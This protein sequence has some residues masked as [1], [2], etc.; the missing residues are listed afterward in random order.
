ML[1][2]LDA[3]SRWH[4]RVFGGQVLFLAL[5]GA[6]VL[7][8]DRHAPVLYL[9][10]LRAMFRM[11]ALVLLLVGLFAR[12]PP[13]RASLCLWDHVLAFVLLGAGCSLA[14]RLLAGSGGP[15]TP[16]ALP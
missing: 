10:E 3:R 11:S 14:L 13:S 7:L 2:R 4:L 8:V 9:L 15:L 6:P 1:Q 16:G 5:T 12:Q